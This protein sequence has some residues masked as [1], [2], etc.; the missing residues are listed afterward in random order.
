MVLNKKTPAFVELE[1]LYLKSGRGDYWVQKLQ[2]DANAHGVATE[3]DA[4]VPWFI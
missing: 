1:F 3:I 4:T 2:L